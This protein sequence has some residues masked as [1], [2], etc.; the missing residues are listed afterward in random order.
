[1][2]DTGD[3][4][5]YLDQVALY[6]NLDTSALG[7]DRVR[8]MTVHNAKGLEFPHVLLAGLEE[9]LFPHASSMDDDEEL[10][11]ERRLFYVGVTRAMRT[12]SLSASDLRRRM[13]TASA[14]GPSRF[15]AEAAEV[16]PEA[17]VGRRLAAPLS[18]GTG[19]GNGGARRGGAGGRSAGGRG[20][21]RGGAR[22]EPGGGVHGGRFSTEDTARDD[23]D[24][25]PAWLPDPIDGEPSPPAVGADESGR[26]STGGRRRVRPDK[27]RWVGRA[28]THRI[29]GEGTVELQDGDGDEA[30][31]TVFFP[32][33]GRKKILARFLELPD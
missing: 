27:K 30:R 10:E 14:G 5:A 28:V 22:G 15:L 25:D 33:R 4:A 21:E 12:L 24:G 16:L 7:D 32:G 18:W 20:T 31:L 26:T 29:F 8:L 23:G 19:W 2:T 11:E 9:G 13:N 3:L 17:G 6:T 1:V